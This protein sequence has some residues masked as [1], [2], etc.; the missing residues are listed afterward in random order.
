LAVDDSELDRIAYLEVQIRLNGD[1]ISAGVDARFG[2]VAVGA[3]GFVV[4]G[5]GR[6]GQNSNSL[7]VNGSG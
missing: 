1:D 2:E 5:A 3:G 6:T 4:K 7:V